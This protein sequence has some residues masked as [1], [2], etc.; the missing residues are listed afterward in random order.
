MAAPSLSVAHQ[1]PVSR[2][3]HACL[4]RSIHSK[5]QPKKRCRVSSRE[6][7]GKVKPHACRA[8]LA[9]VAFFR[10]P[11]VEKVAL[12]IRT[13]NLPFPSLIKESELKSH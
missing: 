2:R 8:I 12:Q 7:D 3:I 13:S 10:V 6:H 11:L 9:Y 4:N 5:S 1:C